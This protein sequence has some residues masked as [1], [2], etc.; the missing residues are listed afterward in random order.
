[1][2]IF[3][4]GILVSL[5]AYTLVETHEHNADIESIV[6][7]IWND[8]VN[9]LTGK[10]WI[11]FGSVYVKNNFIDTIYSLEDEDG[12]RSIIPLSI[13]NKIKELYN[14]RKEELSKLNEHMR[15]NCILESKK[16]KKENVEN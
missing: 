12:F 2:L 9:R 15:I 8:G 10:Y 13:K 3:L 1:M 11:K 4:T 7:G 5:V 6:N 14:K 16:E